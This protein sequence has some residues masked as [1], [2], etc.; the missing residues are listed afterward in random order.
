MGLGVVAVEE[1]VGGQLSKSGLYSGFE[2]G[3][4]LGFPHP[5]RV[6]RR[7][8]LARCDGSSGIDALG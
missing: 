2:V 8:D 1:F 6:K 5:F 4:R 3:R 7:V